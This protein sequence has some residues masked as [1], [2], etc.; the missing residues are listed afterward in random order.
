[1]ASTTWA[2]LV[3]SVQIVPELVRGAVRARGAE[4]REDRTEQKAAAENASAYAA[5]LSQPGRVGVVLM[6]L[7]L[8]SMGSRL[9]HFRL[10]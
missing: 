2:A 5:S 4:Q 1:M 10:L 8:R 9:K 6:G 7:T 3:A